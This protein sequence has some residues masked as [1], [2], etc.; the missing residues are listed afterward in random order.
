MPWIVSYFPTSKVV[1]WKKMCSLDLMKQSTHSSPKNWNIFATEV[2]WIKLHKGRH[3]GDIRYSVWMCCYS[4]LPAITMIQ[5]TRLSNCKMGRPE[6]LQWKSGVSYGWSSSLI[7]KKQ[8]KPNDRE[9]LPRCLAMLK[10]VP[11][12]NT[13]HERLSFFFWT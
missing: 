1:M 11:T 9:F 2:N 13:Q 5:L 8:K 7:R 10:V 3:F 12:P 6:F 4:K